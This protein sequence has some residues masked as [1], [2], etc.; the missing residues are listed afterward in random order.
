V[1]YHGQGRNTLASA[2]EEADIVLTTY[3]TLAADF[4]EKS[5][6]LYEVDWFR[7]VLDEGSQIQ[8][9]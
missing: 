1:K 8:N 3:H 5:S 6:P 2:I 4:R 9:L 7:I